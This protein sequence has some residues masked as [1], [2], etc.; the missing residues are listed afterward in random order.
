MAPGPTVTSP[1]G[2]QATSV[3]ALPEDTEDRALMPFEKRQV[4]NM[5]NQY[6]ALPLRLRREFMQLA[7]HT[8]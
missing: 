6:R 3:A 7:V 1:Y 4:E 2:V 8:H 5:L